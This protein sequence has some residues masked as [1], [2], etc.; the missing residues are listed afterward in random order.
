MGLKLVIPPVLEPLGK[1]EVKRHLRI[2]G[3][4]QDDYIVE[5]IQAIRQFAEVFTNRQF[6]TATYD[7][8]LDRFPTSN[9]HSEF[10]QPEIL[11][12]RPPLQSVTSIS[13][14]DLNGATQVLATSVYEVDTGLEPGIVRLKFDQSWPSTRTHANAITIRFVSGYQDETKIPATIK[15]AM[16]LHAGLLYENRES[17]ITGTIITELKTGGIESLLWAHRIVEAA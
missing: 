15:H 11:I 17:S 14:V 12:P 4:E 2:D 10:S 5:L 6:M 8:F 7:F 16:K 3:S 9:G 1:E 13:Y